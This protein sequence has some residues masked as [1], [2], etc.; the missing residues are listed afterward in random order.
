MSLQTKKEDKV[1]KNKDGLDEK[2]MPLVIIFYLLT[3]LEQKKIKI[4]A[5][6]APNNSDRA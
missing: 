1:K 2:I 6:A 4:F 5:M 3:Y